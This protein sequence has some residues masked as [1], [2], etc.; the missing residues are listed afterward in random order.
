MTLSRQTFP[1][2]RLTPRDV[3]ILLMIYRYDGCVSTQIQRRFWP[4]IGARSAYY[5]R[6]SGLIFHG[7]VRRVALPS[8][9]GYGSGPSFLTLGEVAHP[10]LLDLLD[11]PRAELRRLRHRLIPAFWQHD[12]R[13]RD[14]HLDLELACAADDVEL[15]EWVNEREL[16]RSPIT[17]PYETKRSGRRSP[18]IELIPD[19]AFTLRLHSGA[20]QTFLLECDMGSIPAARMRQKLRGYLLNAHADPRPVLWV[21]PSTERRDSIATWAREAAARLDGADPTIF[22]IAVRSG[23]T[24]ATVVAKPIWFVVGGPPNFSLVPIDSHISIRPVLISP[25]TSPINRKDGATRWA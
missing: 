24:S 25:D 1:G 5:Q 20:S 15:V 21:V 22:W 4:H 2:F 12:S 19:G 11:L 13:V 23:V 14:F 7:Y 10:L 17:V 9:S 3:E 18:A 6:L 8:R 16:K